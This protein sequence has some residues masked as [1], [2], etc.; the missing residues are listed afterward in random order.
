VLLTSCKDD[1]CRLWTESAPY[2]PFAFFCAH[3]IAR[4]TVFTSSAQTAQAIQH[5]PF[6]LHWLNAKVQHA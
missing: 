2:E 4:P 3:V 5:V 1:L 6:V